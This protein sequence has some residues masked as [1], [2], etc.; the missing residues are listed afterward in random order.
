M[1]GV[2]Q[3]EFTQGGSMTTAARVVLVTALLVGAL[4]A[5]GGL[6]ARYPTVT[7]AALAPVPVGMYVLWIREKR[8]D[9]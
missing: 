4:V 2:T 1:V 6:L 8:S 3:V 5:V 9:H 7:L